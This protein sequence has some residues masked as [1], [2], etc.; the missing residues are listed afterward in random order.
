MT[1]TIHA[2]AEQTNLLA[3]NAAIRPPAPA[4]TRRG[5][6]VVAD[7]VRKL[8][9]TSQSTGEIHALVSQVTAVAQ[10]VVAAMG[11]VGEH[12]RHGE[13]QLDAA[14]AALQ[15]IVAASIQVN[16]MVCGIAETN[17][18][19]SITSHDLWSTAR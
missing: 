14:M 3:L 18:Q 15:Q 2:I 8:G 11:Q 5:F 17:H 13:G 19:Q 12:T 6:A 1:E 9:R 4:R 10:S 16:F 7:E